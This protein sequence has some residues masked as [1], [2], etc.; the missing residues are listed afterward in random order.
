MGPRGSWRS[1]GRCPSRAKDARGPTLVFEA[2][3]SITA[4]H[5]GSSGSPHAVRGFVPSRTGLILD[6]ASVPPAARCDAPR[7]V[8]AAGASPGYR[9]R[10]RRDSSTRLRLLRTRPAAL[11]FRHAHQAHIAAIYL[12]GADVAE[13]RA[14]LEALATARAWRSWGRTT[15]LPPPPLR[16]KSYRQASC[17]PMANTRASR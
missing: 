13:P 7:H 14:M 1:P 4:C 5:C 11:P 10:H 17:A 3:A 8:R 6:S 16:L 9:D 2:A 15:T 12:Y